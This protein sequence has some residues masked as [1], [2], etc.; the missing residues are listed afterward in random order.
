MPTLFFPDLNT[1]SDC[2]TADIVPA[3]VVRGGARAGFDRRGRLWIRPEISLPREVLVRLGQF[4]VRAFGSAPVEP[5]QFVTDWYQLIPLE[6]APSLTPASPSVALFELEWAE[7]TGF[8]AELHRLRTGSFAFR[9]FQ[10]GVL[11]RVEK[12]THFSLDRDSER[13]RVYIEAA[14]NV[15]VRLGWQHPLGRFIRPS[16]G[17]Q[18]LLRP[19]RVWLEVSDAGWFACLDAFPAGTSETPL[20]PWRDAPEQA[21]MIR[22]VAQLG[23]GS[24]TDPEQFW[25]IEGDPKRNLHEL[26]RSADE[27]SLQRLRFAVVEMGTESRL[28]LWTKEGGSRVP[29][30]DGVGMRP[31]RPQLFLPVG[32]EPRPQTRDGI[33]SGLVPNDPQRVT[34][35]VSEAGDRF[36]VEHAPVSAF[37]RVSETIDYT[38]TAAPRRLTSWSP[39]VGFDMEPF[40]ELPD[41]MENVSERRHPE[42]K[43]FGWLRSWRGG[44]SR[45]MKVTTTREED[46]EVMTGHGVPPRETESPVPKKAMARELPPEPG[47]GRGRW[48]L[49]RNELQRRYLESLDGGE[50]WVISRDGPALA[51]ALSRCGDHADAA[52][53]WVSVVWEAP[54]PPPVSWAANWATSEAIAGGLSIVPDD[55]IGSIVG[56]LGLDAT[57]ARTRTLAAGLVWAWASG[58]VS[59]LTKQ[60][61][62]LQTFLERDDHALGTR[63]AWLAAQAIAHLSGGDVLA[64]ARARDRIVSRLTTQGPRPEREMPMFQRFVRGTVGT[65]NN[66]AEHLREVREW[67]MR[68]RGPIRRWVANEATA[69]RA[70]LTELTAVEQGASAES[71]DWDRGGR[72]RAFGLEGEVSATLGYLDLMFA[73]GLARCGEQSMSRD[74]AIESEARLSEADPVHRFLSMAFRYRIDQALAGDTAQGPLPAEVLVPLA[75]R[76]LNRLDRYQID[77]FRFHSRIL[78]PEGF[79]DPYRPAL[80]PHPG[81]GGVTSS[82]AALPDIPDLDLL[83]RR[84]RHHL[85]T[86]LVDGVLPAR[87]LFILLEPTPRLD[88]RTAEEVFDRL[89]ATLNGESNG[90][91]RVRLLVR[92]LR[93]GAR[94]ERR[95][96]MQRF[97]KEI[98][99]SIVGCRDPGLLEELVWAASVSFSTLGMT[100]LLAS[101]LIRFEDMLPRLGKTQEPRIMASMAGGWF[102]AGKPT[103]AVA[104][105][106]TIRTRLF[107]TSGL[108]SVERTGVASAYLDAMSCAVGR[109]PS[110]RVLGRVEEVFQRLA[111]VQLRGSTNARYT[112]GP[113]RVAEAAI[114]CGVGPDTR[115]GEKAQ[116]W[117]EEQARTIRRR[118]DGDLDAHLAEGVIRIARRR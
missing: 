94:L 108:T 61:G 1:L 89:P 26:I 64:L 103:R 96:E 12:P 36:R 14:P 32:R 25:M 90:S 4:G 114:R 38:V 7:L 30:T 28:L 22:Q 118:I 15:W 48:H 80:T 11:V 81:D 23:N 109:V 45:S 72:L 50:E 93:L 19:A 92:G 66:P 31:Y 84:V 117:S 76:D 65:S 83:Q 43:W 104:L 51:E 63:S 62:L 16:P 46:P 54:N 41:E 85:K 60:I 20:A 3:T 88:R 44:S 68:M 5:R 2:L 87:V 57:P 56:W 105:S 35:L 21:P 34:W 91:E 59:Q 49:F 73:W 53:C 101:I 79:V 40:Q 67:L 58:M 112:L 113:L 111:G 17:E 97:A 77:T 95:D 13:T 78:E 69:G 10:D 75:G 9:S 6:P 47:R 99:R 29:P 18:L 8:I 71:I 107:T 82:L 116:R 55:P 52:I 102:L 24:A 42:R 110:S 98:S 33:L 70:A 106:E 74:L 115:I 27:M 86:S 39:T 100:D 37:H